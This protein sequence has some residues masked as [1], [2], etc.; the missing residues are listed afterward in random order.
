MSQRIQVLLVEDDLVDAEMVIRALR[1]AG[2]D[3]DWMRVDTED[4]FLACLDPR[5]DI[6]L[7]DHAMPQFSGPRALE[8]LAESG[9]GIPFL[10]ISGTIG[11]DVAVESMK[12][13]A[14]DYL[15]KDR[16]SRLG[17]AVQQC[18]EQR[19]LRLERQRT[20]DALRESDERLKLALAASHMGV[21][22]WDVHSQSVYLSP[23]S[24]LLLGVPHFDGT[25]LAFRQLV[26]PDDLLRVVHCLE[27]AMKDHTVCQV[28][29][30]RIRP[31]RPVSWM[32][33]MGRGK[34]D[35]KGRPLRMVG[36][37]QDIT[38]RKEAEAQIAEQ[39]ALL[40]KAKDAIIVRGL[41]H[42]IL[43]W[44]KGAERLY[45]WTSAEVMGLDP[46][47]FLYDAADQI[48]EPKKLVIEHGEW[49]G[50]LRQ[51]TKDR[52]EVEVDSH[53][54][55]VRDEA[56]QP[57][58][59]LSINTDVT[60]KRKLEAQ[61]FRAQRL[62]SIGTL[63]GGIAHD[64]NNVLT[65]IMMSIDLLRTRA[66]D[67]LCVSTLDT[68]AA[69]A[70]RG[71]SMVSQV[72]SFARGVECERM[73]VGLRPLIDDLIAISADSFPKNIQ[74][75]RF[76]DP[77]L[78]NVMGDSTQIHQVLLNLC[79]NARDA[80]PDGGWL[81]IRADN[82]LLDDH[83]AAMMSGAKAGPYVIVQIAD[84]GIGMRPEIVDRIFDPFFTTKKLGQ[85]TGLGLSTSMA[86]IKSHG[87]FIRVDSE[88]GKGSEFK[89]YLPAE[90][91][92]ADAEAVNMGAA[93]PRGNGELV[94]VVDDEASVREVTQQM[95]ENFGYGALVATDGADA[96][97][98]FAEHPEV[99]VVVMDMMMPV[100]DGPTTIQVLLSMAPDLPI[101]AA[102][103]LA[104]T[105]ATNAVAA[106][107][108]KH[109]LPKPYTGAALLRL[110]KLTLA[111]EG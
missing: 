26:H 89:V 111:G 104:D 55:L 96:V 62:E 87:G 107:G 99:A 25:A 13:G 36:T 77:L 17:Q 98:V 65:P 9:L 42:R 23:E 91:E 30:R 37:A 66:T 95:L 34:Y 105:G 60:E 73:P 74:I 63:A 100:M 3:P 49:S 33:I 108:V 67:P 22:E 21:W 38:R 75:K 35:E 2:F 4:A 106:L 90:G 71:A 11:E 102:S 7:S 76:C 40:D 78:W 48:D 79:I 10:T 54:T 6:I 92:V 47:T 72:L 110:L 44:S 8:L 52:R 29:F 18:L 32:A 24:L 84:T 20:E 45:G 43:F 86:I 64:L 69:S 5:L 56:G 109:F 46:S 70:K 83:Y 12:R 27:A 94:L 15:L 41:D 88:A 61:F 31:D 97:A 1:K 39:A 57:K 28:E 50:A 19:Q 16:L 14:A 53:W 93:P 58:S 81:T 80:M 51:V 82:F 59:V 101:I 103:G 85:G 68:I